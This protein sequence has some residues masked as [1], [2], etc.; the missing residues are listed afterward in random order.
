M[1]NWEH[2]SISIYICDE[3]WSRKYGHVGCI[4]KIREMENVLIVQYT[5]SVQYAIIMDVDTDPGSCVV[6]TLAAWKANRA[7]FDSERRQKS[8]R[9]T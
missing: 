6:S 7:H 5:C 9:I 2:F 3:A 4:S 1:S 8:E